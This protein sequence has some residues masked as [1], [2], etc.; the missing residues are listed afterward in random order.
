MSSLSALKKLWNENSLGV[1]IVG[2][3]TLYVFYLFSGYLKS[4]SG[5]SAYETMNQDRNAAYANSGAGANAAASAPPASG[6]DRAPAPAMESGNEVYSSVSGSMQ[7]TGGGVPSSCRQGGMDN[8]ADLL[9]KDRN[10]EWAQLNPQGK[11]DMANI[12]FLKAGYHM[13]IDTV[14]QTLRN[15]NLQI[16]SEPPNPQVNVGPWNLSTIEPD[17][18]RPPLEIGQ[19]IQ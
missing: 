2:G 8:P 19:G 1:I 10:S 15:P 13:G 7:V 4:K 6:F 14:G 9:P 3:I 18:M 5:Y 16:R 17:F 11:G 12:N